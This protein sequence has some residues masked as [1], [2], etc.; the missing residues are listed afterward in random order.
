MPDL[1]LLHFAEPYHHARHYLGYAIGTGRGRAYAQ[2]QCDG[3]AIGAHEL[4]MAAQWAGIEIE[5]A[6]V[7]VGHGRATRR[8]LKRG[9]NLARHC[10]ICRSA[11]E[12]ALEEIGP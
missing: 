7:W 4:V 9:H 8:E 11:A 6:A 3:H 10:P 12:S 1:Y 5:V 2:A